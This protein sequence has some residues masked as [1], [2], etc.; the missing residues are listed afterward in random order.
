MVFIRNSKNKKVLI[1]AT[2]DVTNV[3]DR[4][5]CCPYSR[6]LRTLEFNKFYLNFSN[7]PITSS[8]LK[9]NMSHI[10]KTVQYL[11]PLI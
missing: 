4:C 5:N 1:K 2:Q 3:Q 10:L 6:I 9:K 7:L 8:I 11:V